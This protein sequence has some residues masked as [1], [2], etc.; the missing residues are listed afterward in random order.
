MQA[1]AIVGGRLVSFKL[2]PELARAQRANA[3]KTMT[4]GEAV[5]FVEKQRRA[6]ALRRARPGLDACVLKPA[7]MP[8][9]SVL[10]KQC[11]RLGCG[12][13]EQKMAPRLFGS[14]AGF[15]RGDSAA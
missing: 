1:K 15:Y 5:A 3:G 6:L 8:N 11:G 4:D 2:S 13:F 7:M 12:L 14:G 9:P 10:I